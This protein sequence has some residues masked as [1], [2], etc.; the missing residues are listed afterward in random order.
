MQNKN[1]YLISKLFLVKKEKWVAN[2][3]VV[4]YVVTYGYF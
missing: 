1:L 4:T 2:A 3:K